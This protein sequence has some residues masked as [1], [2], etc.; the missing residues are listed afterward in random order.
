MSPA[1]ATRPARVL[2]VSTQPFF[3][4]RGSSIRVKF[5]L[6][7]L[8]SLGI[9]ADLLAMPYGVDADDVKA[10]VY[11]VPALPG[12]RNLPIGP[13]AAKLVLDVFILFRT[14]ALALRHRYD[15][16]H[17]TEEGGVIG[18][19]AARL[20]GARCI[21]E[22]HSDPASYAG[23]AVRRVLMRLYRAIE[24]FTARHNDAVICTGPGLERQA[25]DYAP[26]ARIHHIPDIPSSL[27]EPEPGE[28]S[29][30]RAALAGGPDSVIV[31]YVGS[32]AVYQGVDLVFDAIPLVLK[33]HPGARFA[34]IGGTLG[35]IDHYRAALGPAAE[36]VR[37]TGPVDPDRLPA[38]LKASDILLA[39]RRA[40]IN[41]PLKVLD[42]FKA[43]RAIV[44][45]DTEANRLI[46]DE[47]CARLSAF[48]AED[49]AAA[50]GE[51]VDDPGAREHIAAEALAR[52]HTRY[53]F[54]VF[55]SQLAAVYRELLQGAR[56]IDAIPG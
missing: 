40:G 3:Q 24:R 19:L 42:Y 22:K 54:A 25:R 33:R 7:A 14:L 15:V 47:G 49:F 9:S 17:A 44:A 10:R 20:T 21:Y 28:V 37:F 1:E 38:Y 53:N 41:T 18:W 27:I 32:F 39:P 16:I 13:S 30:A 11:R 35:Q 31:T 29:A 26:D 2:L 45:T 56:G 4:W 50:I 43:G 46:L 23:G 8:E 52:Y 55:T 48:R 34:I 5:D 36:A 51:L 6:L 12:V